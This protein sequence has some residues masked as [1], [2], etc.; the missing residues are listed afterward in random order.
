MVSV[1]VYFPYFEML[2]DNRFGDTNIT[3]LWGHCYN[4]S[5]NS[6][7][8]GTYLRKKLFYPPSSWICTCQYSWLCTWSLAV[9]NFDILF[10]GVLPMPWAWFYMLDTLFFSSIFYFEEKLYAYVCHG[11]R[12]EFVLSGAIGF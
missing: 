2:I 9:Q 10:F 6:L 7:M 8:T 4:Y 3:Q 11:Y 1:E 5:R 12:M